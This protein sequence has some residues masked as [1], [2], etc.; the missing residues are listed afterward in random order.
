VWPALI[1]LVA[2]VLASAYMLRLFQDTMN[3]PE[4]PDLPERR[5]MTWVEGLAVAPLVAAFV[6]L[7]VN[8]APLVANAADAAKAIPAVAAQLATP[9]DARVV[10]SR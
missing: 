7:G 3:G 10:G 4:V 6:Y 2:I 8:P 9:E 1:A 5:D